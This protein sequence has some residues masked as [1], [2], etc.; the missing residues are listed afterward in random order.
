[1]KASIGAAL[2]LAST[3]FAGAYCRAQ[4]TLASAVD[5]ALRSNPRVRIAEADV[6]KALALLEQSRDVYIP[7]AS[8]GAGL[9]LSYGYSPYPPTLATF[10]AQSLV[11][12]GSQYSYIRSARA[13]YNASRKS[14]Q[15]VR[16]TVTE[17]T[18]ITFAALQRD[19]EREAALREQRGYAEKLVAI[20]QQRL[21]SGFDTRID[22][23]TSQLS[24]AQIRLRLLRAE[25]ETLNDRDH[26][27]TLLGVSDPTLKVEGGLPELVP[28]ASR[29]SQEAQSPAVASAFFNAKSK[30]AQAAGDARYLYRPQIQF[31]VQYNRYATFT[32]SFKQLQALNPSVNIGANEEVYG[33][34]ISLPIFDRF[35]KAKARESAAD[36]AHALHEAEGLARSTAEN[37][38]RLSR[39]VTELQARM[40]VA[41][42]EQQLAQE[43]LEATLVQVANP[44]STG[45]QQLTPKDEQNTRISER[46]K[47]LAVIDS[48]YQLHEAEIRVLRLTGDLE[49]WVRSSVHAGGNT[50]P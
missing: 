47:Y 34:Q 46:E 32:N 3:S 14:L 38:T 1:M 33:V 48:M 25:N 18:A 4:V 5:L 7:S 42:L 11:Y 50:H 41:A 15:D 40:A 43:Q 23:T 10:N 45:A 37:R 49:E 29:S 12:N 31:L 20:I 2:L 39:T 27:A 28:G 44:N 22:L 16:D 36:A 19:Q 30:A 6:A 8:I 13:G 26:L 24:A 21:D 17:D 9:G 35:R